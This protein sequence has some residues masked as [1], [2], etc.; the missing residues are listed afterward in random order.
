MVA[1]LAE[2]FAIEDDFTVDPARQH[3]GI[4]TL[5]AT[6]D[7]TVLVAE[8]KGK[9]VGMA[10][11]QRLVSTAV[12]APVGIIE[13]VVVQ[14]GCRGNGIGQALIEALIIRSES[15]GYGRLAVGVD[16]RNRSAIPFYEKMGFA[17]SH[18]GLMYRI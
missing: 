1:L 9:T 2:L 10:T 18:M 3:R 7:A 17:T 6:P 14:K 16:Q 5:L 4:E 11:M 12:G 15:Q 13:D 8:Q